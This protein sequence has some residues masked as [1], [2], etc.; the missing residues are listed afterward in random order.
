MPW[1]VNKFLIC[2]RGQTCRVLPLFKLFKV[3]SGACT[4]MTF[5][6]DS[7]CDVHKPKV[8]KFVKFSVQGW[9]LLKPC[10]APVGHG[11]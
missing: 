11:L 8:Y 4:Q 6:D 9:L 10:L 1:Y 3:K 5:K 7:V 2:L